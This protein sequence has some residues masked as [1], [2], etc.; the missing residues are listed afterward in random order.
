MLV[1]SSIPDAGIGVISTTFIP[2]YTWLAEYEGEIDVEG[3]SLSDYTWD[4]SINLS[5][6]IIIFLLLLLKF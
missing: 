5:C 3:H 4:V 1:N 6:F 2:K